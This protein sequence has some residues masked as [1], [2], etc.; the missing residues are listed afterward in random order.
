[1]E[2]KY[3]TPTIEEFH[4]GFEFEMY[5]GNSVWSKF[6]CEINYDN[7]GN[8]LIRIPDSSETHRVK[9][10]D[11]EDIESLRFE[12]SANYADSPELG[13]L[14]ETH[15]ISVKPFIQYLLYYNP[16][17][18]QLRIERIVNCGTGKEDYLFNGKIKN[19]SELVKL[20]KQLGI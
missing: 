12:Y 16:E 20:L 9:Y 8:K 18:L 7:D 10:L 13:F 17:T 4:V 19:K 15:V 6:I 14:K 3:Y 2:N 5:N 11:K 1:M